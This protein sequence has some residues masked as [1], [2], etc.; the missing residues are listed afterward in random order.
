MLPGA[1]SACCSAVRV[2]TAFLM[3]KPLCC[4]HLTCAG[5]SLCHNP[6][7]LL[8]NLQVT[9]SATGSTSNPAPNAPPSPPSPPP[10]SPSPP[11]PPRCAKYATIAAESVRHPSATVCRNHSDVRPPQMPP[12]KLTLGEDAD[13]MTCCAARR[14]GRCR[15]S[16]ARRRSQSR[17]LA[18]SFWRRLPFSKTLP[19]EVGFRLGALDA[20]VTRCCHSLV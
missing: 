11:P 19:F 2:R 14:R 6:S 10:A 5:P 13:R 18:S 20:G 7:L 16:R 4:M 8:F 3:T 17:R 1:H 12:P 9:I 15:M